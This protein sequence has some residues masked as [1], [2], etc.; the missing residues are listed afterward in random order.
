MQLFDTELSLVMPTS[1]CPV[2]L[3]TYFRKGVCALRHPLPGSPFPALCL[4]ESQLGQN[5]Y[6]TIVKKYQLMGFL[7]LMFI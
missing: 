5:T 2:V 4:Y 6:P 3:L 7:N 1:R